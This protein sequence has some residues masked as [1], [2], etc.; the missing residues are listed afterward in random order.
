M[1]G[2]LPLD[3]LIFTF[4]NLRTL[5]LFGG[6]LVSNTVKIKTFISD[7]KH[8]V[9]I[10]LCKTAGSIHLFKFTGTL[11]SEN[12]KLKLNRIWDIIEIYWKE[13]NMTLNGNKINSPKS[14]TIQF[15]DKFKIRC[16]V[17]GEPLLF[18]IMLKQGFTWFTL[19]YNSPPETV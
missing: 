17:R 11:T 2:I 18:H 19:A 1:L 16:H 5:K 12:V 7:T 8:Y 9:P 14:V 6:H 10:K 3:L 13:V 15:W 4:I